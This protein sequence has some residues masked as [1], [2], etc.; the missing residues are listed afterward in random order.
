MN[1]YL[2]INR[3]HC[4]SNPSW[5]QKDLLL[6]NLSSMIDRFNEIIESFIEAKAQVGS[7]V[8]RFL[9]CLILSLSKPGIVHCHTFPIDRMRCPKMSWKEK[10]C[11]TTI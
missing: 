4:D 10:K 8:Y 2:F 11:T 1:I 9:D 6:P 5:F 7:C 3:E